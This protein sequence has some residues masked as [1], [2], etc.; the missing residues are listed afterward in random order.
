MSN[1]WTDHELINRGDYQIL[2][3]KV[4]IYQDKLNTHRI[5][6]YHLYNQDTIHLHGGKPSVI[7]N[8][9]DLVMAISGYYFHYGVSRVNTDYDEIPL[10][11]RRK[12]L[13]KA[14]KLLKL[15]FP[16]WKK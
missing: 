1:I 12:Y 11:E 8:K 2:L 10:S 3:V 6:A 13:D 9:D 16:S 4:S 14:R 15:Y 7:K 5:I